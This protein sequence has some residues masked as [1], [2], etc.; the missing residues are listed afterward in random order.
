[1]W[2]ENVFPETLLAIWN[3]LYV[4]AKM[5][6]AEF[7]KCAFCL[8]TFSFSSLNAD[9]VAEARLKITDPSSKYKRFY[10]KQDWK[11][12]A[13]VPNAETLAEA[14]LKVLK[15]CLKYK[16]LVEARLKVPNKYP[17]YK[18]L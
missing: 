17:K 4:N 9:F 15:L 8:W 10:Q 14:R 11:V 3:V 2:S 18:R 5:I 16:R 7:T 6:A 12:P 13:S 1:M